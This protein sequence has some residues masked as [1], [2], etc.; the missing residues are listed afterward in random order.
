MLSGLVNEFP[1]HEPRPAN[2]PK[3]LAGI[4]V[5]DFTH[6]IAGPFATM[7]LADMGAEVIKIE[8][9]G[10]GDEF[11]YYPP[12]HPQDASIGGPYLWAN[13]N[14]RSIAL[15]LKSEEGRRIAR[16]LVA[17]ADIVAENFSTGVMERLGLGYEACRELNPQVIYCSVSAYG[18]EGAFADRLGFDPIAQAESGFVSM[19]GYP[20]R[21]GVRALSPVMD[22][23]TA[24]MASNAML[25]A[26]VARERTGKG[27][28]VE[29]SLFDNAVLMTGYATVQHLFTGEE[30]RRHG[31]TSPDTCPSGV[32]KAAD[33]A[34]Y[35]NCGNNKIF[36]RLANQVLEMPELAADPVLADRNGRIARRDELFRILDE[37]FIRHPWAHWQQRMRAASIPCGE[38]RTVGEALRS[39][40]ARERKLVSRL[41]HP[42]LGWLPNINLPFRFSE[43]PIDDPSPAPR[44]G[45]H[46]RSILTE[47]LGY[48]GDSAD[49]LLQSGAVYSCNQVVAAAGGAE[50]LT[51]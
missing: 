42:E 22:I 48:P 44:V 4:R 15:D 24:M 20:D 25:G 23:S 10:R 21:L 12:A 46:S 16:E 43:T 32:F 33:K 39:P 19:N 1:E 18:R 40:E 17:T 9:P 34:F 28:A 31:N 51:S 45:E 35:I 38:V 5:V 27:Q 37:A 36:H 8:A 11:R 3:A 47:V 14:K 7:M 41:E 2:A 49:A 50:V 26:L 30:P 29:V 6:F 13:R